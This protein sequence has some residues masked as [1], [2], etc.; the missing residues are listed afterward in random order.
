MQNY[1]KIELDKERN[2]SD[3]INTTF[4]LIRSEFL[5]LIKVLAI[6]ASLPTLLQ[7]IIQSYYMK[8][9]INETLQSIATK[10]MGGSTEILIW[11]PWLMVT[12]II[13]S[14]FTWGLGL[15]YINQYRQKGRDGFTHSDVWRGFL[16]KLLKI[17]WLNIVLIFALIFA[18]LLLIIP[19]IWFSVVSALIM[20]VLIFENRSILNSI[21]RAVYLIRSN[22]WKTLGLLVV[23][24]IIQSMISG[25]FSI[26]AMVYGI[27]LGLRGMEGE[28][29]EIANNPI[30]IT[31]SI[32][33]SVIST[34]LNLLIIIT[35]ALQFFNLR[36]QKEKNILI[37]RIEKINQ[38]ND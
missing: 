18:F 24:A 20:P 23:V 12:S 38:A 21:S 33:T 26:P 28:V 31:F 16:N 5:P 8:D 6:Y 25:L 22:W 7:A 29:A 32:V 14:I 36:E 27:I 10:G 13:T 11:L 17:S 35:C 1:I 19:G 2:F 4:E 15:E 9:S 30:L 3:I 34:W 37:S